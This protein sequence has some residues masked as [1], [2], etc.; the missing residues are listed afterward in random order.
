MR[1][2]L[3]AAGFIGVASL[4][5]AADATPPAYTELKAADYQRIVDDK[6]VDLWTITSK[7]GVVVKITNYGARIEQILAPDRTGKLGDITLGYPTLEAQQAGQA[8]LGAFIGRYANRIA[9]G[10]FT[11]DGHSYQLAIN[12][13][14]SGA[15]AR[16]NTLHGGKKGSRFVVFDARQL[17]PSQV[18]MSYV[19]K[20]GEENFSGTLP[21]RVLYSLAD[22]GALTIAWEAAA[23]D[24]TTVANF[25]QHTF[26]NLSG[27]PSQTIYG[28]ELTLNADK[29]LDIG[30]ALV[31]TGAILP[32][33]GTPLDFTAAKPIG[34]DIEADFP[35]LKAAGG[36]DH[37][38]VIA[39]KGD[40]LA[41]AA[42]VHEP[43][44]GRILEVW[45][46]EP[47]VQ[48]YSGNFLEGKAP[49]DTGKGGITYPF[50]S[51]F[52]L[53]PSHFPDSVNHP[54]F[55]STVLKP[56]QWYTGAIVYKFLTDAK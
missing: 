53:E 55:P 31:P 33:A 26:F 52:C 50:R 40:G 35:A 17:S 22:D 13:L 44:S 38:F 46:T 54:E 8:S 34:R 6:A 28:H 29:Y 5:Y 42:R 15:N 21:A 1:T 10:K 30:P 27:D 24:K 48:F 14:A 4:A 41:L 20:D 36:Y 43:K 16:Q 18:E 25:T 49:R 12:D 19:F 37:H 23:D 3:L 56:G 9:E 32:V 11:L 45:T 7:S 2:Y 39:R 51:A 47:G